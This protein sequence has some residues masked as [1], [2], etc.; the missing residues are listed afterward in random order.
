[1]AALANWKGGE[2][3]LGVDNEGVQVGTPL[4][5]EQVEAALFQESA[6]R[7]VNFVSDMKRVVRIPC[8]EVQ[9]APSNPG[10]RIFVIEVLEQALPVGVWE[11]GGFELWVRDGSSSQR[12]N[13]FDGIGW[14]RGRRRAI[15]LR[16]IYLEFEMMSRQVRPDEGYTVGV[17]PVLP[18]FT[19]CMEDGTLYSVLTADDRHVLIGAAMEGHLGGGSTGFIGTLLRLRENVIRRTAEMKEWALIG[20]QPSIT[21]L[22]IKDRLTQEFGQV[23]VTLKADRKAFRDY[24]DRERI[25]VD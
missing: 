5:W 13:G 12:L 17:T 15:V 10:R 21:P 24:L 23:W 1:V 4:T 22:V 6:P 11:K 25:K 7:S 8:V 14:F 3:F 18:Y 19:R 2:V 20:G 16:E 9:L